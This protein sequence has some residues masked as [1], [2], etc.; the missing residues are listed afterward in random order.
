MTLAPAWNPWQA[1]FKNAP[2]LQG[3]DWVI[4][5]EEGFDRPFALLARVIKAT[6][7]IGFE[8]RLDRPSLYFTD[9]VAAPQTTEVEHQIETLLRLLRPLGIVKPTAYTVDFT[10]VLPDS[11]RQFAT[12]RLAKRPFAANKPF[13]LLNLSSAGRPRFR[14]EDF[15]SLSKRIIS[16]TD[17][18]IGLIAAPADQQQ[19]REIALCMASPRIVA[20]DTPGPLEVAALLEHAPPGAH[21]RRRDGAPRRRHRHARR[22]SLVRRLL[23]KEPL[24]QFEARLCPARKNGNPTSPWTASWTA[25]QPLFKTKATGVKKPVA[26][27]KSSPPQSN[28]TWPHSSAAS[29]HPPTGQFSA[30]WPAGARLSRAPSNSARAPASSASPAPGLATTLT[31]SVVFKALRET[32]PEL[33]IAAVVH[34]RRRLLVEHNPYV[35]QIFSFHKGPQAFWQ[36]QKEL[37]AAGPWQAILQLRGNDP[38]P[39]CLSFM[40]DPDVTVSVPNMTQLSELCGHQVKQPDWDETHG[41][42]QTLRLARYVGATTGEPHLVYAVQDDDRARPGGKIA[43]HAHREKAPACPA[44]WRRP[45]RGLAGLAGGALRATDPALHDGIEH[46]HL[47]PRRRGP[48]G[49]PEGTRPAFR[50]RRRQALSQPRE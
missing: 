25:L 22:D 1:A 11:A 14:E 38:E 29:P 9:P 8:R 44:T 19:A 2:A 21:P 16:A 7:R 23:R 30:S 10:L 15:I 36:L 43:P 50:Q 5:A 41:V 49:A 35:D 3:Y 45:A 34:R 32:Y 18:A 39:R 40:I 46:G 24:P 20:V 48:G 42:E 12:E 28:Q 33:H 37:R 6:V 47:Y 13:M 4:V 26:P 27:W 17:L 31:D